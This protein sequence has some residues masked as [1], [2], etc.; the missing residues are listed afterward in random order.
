MIEMMDNLA[1][2]GVAILV[3]IGMG[4]VVWLT[5]SNS[6]LGTQR[7]YY[8]LMLKRQ[9]Q[10]IKLR[11]KLIKLQEDPDYKAWMKALDLGF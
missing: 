2:I 11:K 1:G 5:F 6:E 4:V 7:K 3:A 8:R 9:K 10:E